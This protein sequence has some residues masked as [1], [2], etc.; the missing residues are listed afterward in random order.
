MKYCSQCGTAISTQA[1]FCPSCGLEIT[2]KTL[3]NE[4]PVEP[5][6]KMQKGVTKSLEDSAQEFV[7]KQTNEIVSKTMPA[8]T[9]TVAQQNSSTPKSYVTFWLWVYLALSIGVVAYRGYE[10]NNISLAAAMSVL[11]VAIVLFRR[12][13][14][15]PINLLVKI[16]LL[17]Q[18]AAIIYF[19]YHW[20]Q[21][22]L[23]YL[24][25]QIL[26]AL[27]IVCLILVFKGNK[28]K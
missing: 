28:K 10:F 15:N 8:T 23:S 24:F 2:S 19:G 18:I 22:L 9:Q 7:Q 20:A 3:F 14:P 5:A 13:K 4:E 25:G 26:A 12:K 17:V 16:I 6:P 27:L 21:Y 1:K 11:T